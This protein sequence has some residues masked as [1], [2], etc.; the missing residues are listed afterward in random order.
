[1][2]SGCTL[3]YFPILPDKEIPLS[4]FQAG[5]HLMPSRHLA[6]DSNVGILYSWGTKMCTLVKSWGPAEDVCVI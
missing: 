3:N 2:K 4:N 5:I 6:N 1:M